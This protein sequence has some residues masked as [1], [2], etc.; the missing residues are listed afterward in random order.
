MASD[1]SWSVAWPTVLLVPEMRLD[2][3]SEMRLYVV[4]SVV[5]S[6]DGCDAELTVGS[7]GLVVAPRQDRVWVSYLLEVLL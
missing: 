3:P 5:E 7:E 2:W 4:G 1:E 6:A